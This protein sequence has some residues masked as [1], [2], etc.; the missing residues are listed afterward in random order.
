MTAP[1]PADGSAEQPLLKF[2]GKQPP[3]AAFAAAKIAGLQLRTEADAKRTQM[4]Q[5]AVEL[6][7]GCALHR[8]RH[9]GCHQSPWTH[10]A[11]FRCIALTAYASPAGSAEI[12]SDY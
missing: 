6:P 2:S 5:A 1:T 8:L 9:D 12:G 10:Q 7:T 4:A 3:L 11:I